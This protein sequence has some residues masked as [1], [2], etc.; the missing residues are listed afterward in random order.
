MVVRTTKRADAR[1]RRRRQQLMARQG[2]MFPG[3]REA[4]SARNHTLERVMCII[5]SK[6]ENGR[7]PRGIIQEV[8]EQQ[9]KVYPWLTR[10]QIDG[11]RKRRRRAEEQHNDHLLDD[12]A[13]TETVDDGTFLYSVGQRK[14]TTGLAKM[15][16]INR[17][18]IL[19]D[20][21]SDTWGRISHQGSSDK[22]ELFEIIIRTNH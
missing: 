13:E 11:L 20:E 10:Y 16:L 1:R 6:E 17:H 12:T 4:Q 2:P 15:E 22:T 9:R 18:K 7:L 8:V 3:N 14:G 5:D 19:V 21:I